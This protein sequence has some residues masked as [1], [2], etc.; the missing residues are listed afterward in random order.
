MTGLEKREVSVSESNSVEQPNPGFI[1]NY[2]Q[3]PVFPYYDVGRNMEKLSSSQTVTPKPVSTYAAREKNVPKTNDDSLVNEM[4][5]IQLRAETTSRRCCKCGYDP[6]LGPHSS[7]LL[8]KVR[9]SGSGESDFVEVE[10]APPTYHTL[11]STCCK[12]L[13]LAVSDMA[14]I[15]KLPNVLV[16]KDRDVQ[17]MADGQELEVV[18]KDSITSSSDKPDT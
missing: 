2:L 6:S 8:V 13:E 7:P 1:P 3:H 11:V 14:K 5:N 12:E 10:V 17:R 9:V 18:M 16:R 4:S 15:R